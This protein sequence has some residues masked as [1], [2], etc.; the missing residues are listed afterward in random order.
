MLSLFEF[1]CHRWL[2]DLNTAKGPQVVTISHGLLAARHV[3]WCKKLRCHQVEMY[4]ED[5]GVELRK[6][7]QKCSSACLELHNPKCDKGLRAQ[8][9]L[10]SESS[11][12]PPARVCCRYM[13]RLVYCY[14]VALIYL[15]V[16]SWVSLWML[17]TSLANLKFWRWLDRGAVSGPNTS[18]PTRTVIG[19]QAPAPLRAS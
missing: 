18:K 6:F 14:Y 13:S 8:V 4:G 5:G 2:G 7:Q 11:D 19:G 3:A 9:L 15:N 17:G 12:P 16:S 1:L 10:A